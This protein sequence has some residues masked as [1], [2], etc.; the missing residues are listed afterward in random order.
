ME[1]AEKSQKEELDIDYTK[2]VNAEESIPG[3]Q[4]MIP[5]GTIHSSGRNQLI[6]E[7]G[8]LTIGSYTYK[9]YDYNRKDKNGNNA[10][11]I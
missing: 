8:S 9:I 2:Y 4:F 10:Q 1:L 3:K 6:L 11:F 5:A 7:L